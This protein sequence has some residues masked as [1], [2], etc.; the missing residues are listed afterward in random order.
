MRSTNCW[1]RGQYILNRSAYKPV[2]VDPKGPLQLGQA[3]NAVE[4]ARLD[5]AEKYAADTFQKALIALQNA[6]D[7]LNGKSKDR[8]RSRDQC[9]RSRADGGRRSHHHLPQDPRRTTR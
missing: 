3:E 9:A 1:Q 6:E 4:I 2:K 7:F 8:K 5:G